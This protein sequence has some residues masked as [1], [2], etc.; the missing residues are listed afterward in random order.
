[1]AWRKG[2]GDLKSVSMRVAVW[3]HRGGGSYEGLSGGDKPLRRCKVASAVD[4]LLLFTVIC[5]I[6]WGATRPY[7]PDV[8][9]KVEPNAQ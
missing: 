6:V 2:G 4:F 3:R 7:E 5:L 1:M 8:V 9:V